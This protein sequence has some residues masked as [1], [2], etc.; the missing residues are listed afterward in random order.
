[1]LRVWLAWSSLLGCAP[2]RTVRI[3]WI[4]NNSSIQVGNRESQRGDAALFP[5]PVESLFGAESPWQGCWRAW[6]R[7]CDACR[8]AGGCGGYP[9]GSGSRRRVRTVAVDG[10]P[11]GAGVLAAAAGAGTPLR[12][13]C[14][15]C[16]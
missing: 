7:L 13:G 2:G 1:M 16:L 11:T 6:V 8:L 12:P 5:L 15:G 14:F 3:A 10:S 4:K 9:P